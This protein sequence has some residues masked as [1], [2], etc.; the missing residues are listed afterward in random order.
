MKRKLYRLEKGT[1]KADSLSSAYSVE[2]LDDKTKEG[3]VCL[4]VL[5]SKDWTNLPHMETRRRSLG[6]AVG[7][8]KLFAVGGF[9]DDRNA[10]QSGEYLDLMNLEAGWKN[11][12]IWGLRGWFGCDL[13]G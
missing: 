6:V 4:K 2:R 5:E 13:W 8:G 1:Y 11:S 3:S 10:L 7:D 12:L 9:D